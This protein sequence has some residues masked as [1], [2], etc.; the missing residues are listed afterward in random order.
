MGYLCNQTTENILTISPDS[1][2]AYFR[3]KKELPVHTEGFRRTVEHALKFTYRG[4]VDNYS[5]VVEPL[6]WLPELGDLVQK[7]H[8]VAVTSAPDDVTNPP[9][10]QKW[11]VK[12]IPGS[13]LMDIE[14][15][16]GHLHLLAP[17]NQ[18]R[19]FS[20]LTTGS[21]SVKS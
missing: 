6:P 7:G 10:M 3:G 16:W 8:A 17:E 21:D 5:L 20:F 11:W 12:T 18:R 19:V 2:A 13:V 9:V 4:I 15:G 1:K 14:P